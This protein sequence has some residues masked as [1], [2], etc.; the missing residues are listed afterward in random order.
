[1]KA[2]VGAF[3]QEKA[4]V[5]AFSVIVQPVVE[6]MEYCTALILGVDLVSSLLLPAATTSYVAHLAGAGCGL[7]LGLVVLKNRR[8]QHWEVWLRAACCCLAAAL[9]LLAAALNVVLVHTISD[10]EHLQHCAFYIP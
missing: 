2:L 4:L 7:L 1:M 8:V 9:I 5:G 6:P 10:L 3:N